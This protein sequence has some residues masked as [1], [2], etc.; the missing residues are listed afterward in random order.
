MQ[1]KEIKS[2]ESCIPKMSILICEKNKIK[3]NNLEIKK[4]KCKV[5]KGIWPN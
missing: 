3:R 2:N 1:L 5:V 4:I